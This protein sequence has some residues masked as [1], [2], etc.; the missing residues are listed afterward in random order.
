MASR[1]SSLTS[2]S[3]RWSLISWCVRKPRVLPILM[4][5]FSSW[6][7][8]V[9][10]SSVSAVSSRP[11][12]RISARSLA[13]DTFMRE[14]LGLDG[15]FAFGGFRLGA[16][17]TSL[18]GSGSANSA[19][20][21]GQ[22]HFIGRRHAG[23][24]ALLALGGLGVCLGRTRAGFAGVLASARA[25]A[26]SGARRG[27]KAAGFSAALAC[28]LGRPWS[29]PQARLAFGGNRCGGRVGLWRRRR[30]AF[31]AVMRFLGWRAW[32]R[33]PCAADVAKLSHGKA[34]R[35]E[36]VAGAWERASS[37]ELIGSAAFADGVDRLAL[38][39]GGRGPD[40]CCCHSCRC[41]KRRI[42]T[43]HR[44]RKPCLTT[45]RGWPVRLSA[46]RS[47]AAAH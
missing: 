21:V 25:P 42:I 10:S 20:D 47:G 46:A 7:R 28:G 24:G 17:S 45:G 19:V 29:Q 32:R 15:L 41:G 11:N 9:A 38:D 5:V 26:F 30:R 16:A 18:S 44:G 23:L 43:S 8:L 36:Q 1:I 35:S 4:S 39:E 2:F 27:F 37:R 6:R 12:S 13:R 40:G 34:V 22:V 3:G 14:R 31:L 33:G